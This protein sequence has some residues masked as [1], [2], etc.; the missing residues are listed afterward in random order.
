LAEASGGR[1]RKILIPVLKERVVVPVP[2]NLIP[3]VDLSDWPGEHEHTGLR[4]M[5]GRSSAMLGEPD[6]LSFAEAAGLISQFARLRRIAVADVREGVTKP[7][8]G[9]EA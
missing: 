4:T 1:D 3:S 5:K 2:F 6:C 7:C 8:S 9:P